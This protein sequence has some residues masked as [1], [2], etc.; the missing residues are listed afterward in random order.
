MDTNE[1]DRVVVQDVKLDDS[2]PFAKGVFKNEFGRQRRVDA[3]AVMAL[4][5]IHDLCKGVRV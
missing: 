5:M 1:E 3:E 4:L 2:E